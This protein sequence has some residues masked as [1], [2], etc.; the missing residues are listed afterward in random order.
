MP[1]YRREVWK[2][3]TSMVNVHRCILKPYLLVFYYRIKFTKIF[4]WRKLNTPSND[5]KLNFTWIKYLALLL[6]K[7]ECLSVRGIALFENS[8]QCH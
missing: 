2:K 4:L 7:R 3:K 1:A 8:G 6:I 5:C